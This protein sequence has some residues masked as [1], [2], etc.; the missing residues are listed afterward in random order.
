MIP[1]EETKTAEEIFDRIVGG[2]WRTLAP[3]THASFI[4]AMEE[5]ASEKDKRIKELEEELKRRS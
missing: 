3:S 4:S 2:Y 1:K 5:Y